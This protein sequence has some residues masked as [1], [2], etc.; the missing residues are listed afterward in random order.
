MLKGNGEG[1]LQAYTRM[2]A[3]MSQSDLEV[4]VSGKKAYSTKNRIVIPAM[5]INNVK[6]LV[7]ATGYAMHEE[8]HINDTDFDTWPSE[9][10]LARVANWFEDVRIEARQMRRFL[11]ARNRLASLVHYLVEDGFLSAPLSSDSTAQRIS[12]YLLYR[13]RAEVL[14]QKALDDYAKKAEALVREAIP[15]SA[16]ARLNVMMFQIEDATSTQDSIDLANSILDMLK[17]EQEKAEEES[18]KQQQQ[19]GQNNDPQSQP[20]ANDEE[21]EQNNA[22]QT[23]QAGSGE[24]EE[25]EPQEP[26]NAQGGSSQDDADEEEGQGNSPQ[27]SSSGEDNNAAEED[28]SQAAQSG[29]GSASP[30]EDLAEQAKNLKQVLNGEDSAGHEDLGRMLEKVL[31][32]L[33]EENRATAVEIPPS[34]EY[35]GSIGDPAQIVGRIGDATKALKRRVTNLLEGIDREKRYNTSSGTRLDTRRMMG[36]ATGN[37]RVFMKRIEGVEMN[38]AVQILIDR[39]GSMELGRR[40]VVAS[41]AALSLSCALEGV[42]GLQSSTLAFPINV[43]GNE[44]GVA[45]LSEFGERTAH[46]ATRF[47]ALTADGYTPMAEA[48]LFSGCRLAKRRE[49]RKILLV[50]TDGQPEVGGELSSVSRAKAR[51]MLTELESANIEVM[52][53][54]IKIDVS[55]L[56]GNCKKVDDLAELPNAVFEMIQTKLLE[57]RAA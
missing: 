23:P 33:H 21:E 14:G 35:R 13:L 5:P 34:Q 57:R 39:S 16:M 48:L 54:G 53:I 51:A 36:V 46:A 37:T 12:S 27:S 8:G 38:T 45:I 1:M 7:I 29:T 31:N 3:D 28:S 10:L 4:V 17:E 42:K 55:M 22:N 19:A 47:A 49:D 52:A 20:G 18:K 50:I 56:F 15:A 43:D 30:S 44:N 24:D 25:G 2:L 32:Q 9:E 6:A 40:I 11:G 26:Q 41:E